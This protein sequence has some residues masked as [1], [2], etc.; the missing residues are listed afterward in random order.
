MEATEIFA[1]TA[2]TCSGFAPIRNRGD[3]CKVSVSFC[4]KSDASLVS[5]ALLLLCVA[6]LTV[7]MVLGVCLQQSVPSA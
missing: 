6:S 2:V 3:N 4:L 1:L 5:E 7:A